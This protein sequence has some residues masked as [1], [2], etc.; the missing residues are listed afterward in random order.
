M[1]ITKS[2][3]SAPRS[4]G[5]CESNALVRLA[6]L[7]PAAHGLGNRCSIRLSYRRTRDYG[8]S[9]FGCSD[10]R[11]SITGDS[12]NGFHSVLLQSA[13][14]STRHLQVLPGSQPH[15]GLLGCSTHCHP[16]CPDMPPTVRPHLG[17]ISMSTG[18]IKGTFKDRQLTSRSVPILSPR[19]EYPRTRRCLFQPPYQRCG[20]FIDEQ[21]MFRHC[22]HPRTEA[23]VGRRWESGIPVSGRH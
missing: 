16:A 23:F 21:S 6:G 22:A 1:R 17:E 18:M 15:Q 11:R 19:Y 9:H 5:S 12:L 10:N 20:A 3:D 8:L 7:E 14:I 2:W 4:H 13:R